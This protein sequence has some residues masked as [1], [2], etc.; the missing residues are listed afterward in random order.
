MPAPPVPIQALLLQ[1]RVL[2][3]GGARLE[4]ALWR[5]ARGLRYRLECE[6]A[7]TML[8]RYDNESPRGH[9]R[10]LAGRA[11]PY[12]FRSVEQLRYDFERD[13]GAALR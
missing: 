7:G 12:A 2:R 5:D 1:E 9:L 4:I 6:R 13:M 3:A 10:T 8:V 11:M